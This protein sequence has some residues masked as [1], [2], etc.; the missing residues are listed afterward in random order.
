MALNDELE[1]ECSVCGVFV[2]LLQRFNAWSEE[3]NE[4]SHQ[5]HHLYNNSLCPVGQTA[6]LW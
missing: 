5:G 4:N 2:V 1:M 3:N 6:E